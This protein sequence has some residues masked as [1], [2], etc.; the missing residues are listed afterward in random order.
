MTRELGINDKISCHDTKRYFVAK[1]LKNTNGNIALK[2]E[3][4]GHSTWDMVK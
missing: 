3:C 4:A 1:F 2:A